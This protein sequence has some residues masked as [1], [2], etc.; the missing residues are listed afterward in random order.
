MASINAASKSIRKG[1]TEVTNTLEN[2]FGENVFD[3]EWRGHR[4]AGFQLKAHFTRNIKDTHDDYVR[5]YNQL[6]DI[7]ENQCKLDIRV[8]IFGADDGFDELIA[9]IDDNFFKQD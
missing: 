6:K 2:I 7:L 9:C 5:K 4:R 3:I 1:M 8:T